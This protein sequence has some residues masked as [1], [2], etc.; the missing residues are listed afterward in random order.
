MPTD[1]K[2]SIRKTVLLTLSAMM[3]GS[4]VVFGF[5]VLGSVTSQALTNIIYYYNAMMQQESPAP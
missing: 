5:V 3:I 1:S 4:S 2:Q